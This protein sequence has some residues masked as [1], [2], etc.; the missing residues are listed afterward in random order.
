MSLKKALRSLRHPSLRVRLVFIFTLLF[1]TLTAAFASFLYFEMIRTLKKDFD[2]A[3]YNYTVDVSNSI[4][5]D[6]SGDVEVTDFNFEQSKVLPFPLGTALIQLRNKRGIIL[7]QQGNFGKFNPHALLATAPANQIDEATFYSIDA[8]D[9]Q[10]IPN[11]EASTYRLIVFPI[12]SNS[13]KRKIYLEIAVPMRLLEGQIRNR[14]QFIQWG[15]PTILL[16]SLLGA[17]YFSSRALRPMAD[18]I[19]I[20]NSMNPNDLSQRIPVPQSQDEIQT[21]IETLN[22]LFERIQNAYLSQER[23]V[24]DASHQLLTPISLVRANLELLKGRVN[25]ELQNEFKHSIE[26]VDNLARIVQQMLILARI[27]AGKDNLNPILVSADEVLFEAVSQAEKSAS[28]KGIQFRIDFRSK[29]V[30]EMPKISGE[31]ELLVHLIRNL[32]ENAIKYS[33][34]NSIIELA[35]SW[36][37]SEVKIEVQDE[38]PGIPV[39]LQSSIFE[40]FN[41]GSHLNQNTP[42]FGLGLSIAQKIALLHQGQL[43]CE[44]TS[45][46]C[47]FSLILLKKP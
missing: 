45:K 21:L 31:F 19:Q 20:A 24:A 22:S 27:D 33:P 42:G 25:L 35:L 43:V 13:K 14:L 10:L 32:I 16:L 47:R 18:I 28:N 8:D 26:Q 34:A 37:M 41:R 30:T 29:D 7:D 39:E 46:G 15:I 12:E 4:E 23:F 6:R 36:N 40:R 44:N 2:S 5:Y 9:V 1:G 17:L 3:L 38:G 11:A